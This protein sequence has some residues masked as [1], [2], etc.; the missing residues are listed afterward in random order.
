MVEALPRVLG[1]SFRLQ[2]DAGVEMDGAFGPEAGALA[3]QR[4]MAVEA[5]IEVL[6]H[7]LAEAAL[8]LDAESVADVEILA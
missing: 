2:H 3:L 5:A 4:H 1:A 6:L 8:D 7:R